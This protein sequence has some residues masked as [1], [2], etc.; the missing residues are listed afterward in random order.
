MKNVA[1][2]LGFIAFLLLATVQAD[3]QETPS[4]ENPP[5]A[6]QE[7]RAGDITY[8]TG[9]IGDDEKQALDAVKKDYNLK[10]LNSDREGAYVS[11]VVITL[12]GRKGN[13]LLSTES[14]PFF[15]AHL[16]AGTY[17]ITAQGVGKEQKKRIKIPGN[18]YLHFIWE[19]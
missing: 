16:P 17:S 13:E 2:A 19:E 9:G 4:E 18:S 7:Q 15:Y 6:L 10:I 11:D 12:Y 3:A 8:V 14:G 5:P 1:G